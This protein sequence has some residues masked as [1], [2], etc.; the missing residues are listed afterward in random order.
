M[1]AARIA[2]QSPNPKFK[3]G[4]GNL[5]KMP[6]GRERSEGAANLMFFGGSPLNSIVGRTGKATMTGDVGAGP[7]RKITEKAKQDM[8][9]EQTTKDTNKDNFDMENVRKRLLE[10][11]KEERAKRTQQFT[12]EKQIYDQSL[13]D[14]VKKEMQKKPLQFMVR[15]G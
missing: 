1:G 6:E 5:T 8:K 9:E 14:S 7:F 10:R 3:E 15:G 13:P 2:S 4:L 11:A 12:Q